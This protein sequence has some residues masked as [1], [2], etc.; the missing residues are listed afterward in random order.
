MQQ[1]DDL[2]A[3]RDAIQLQVTAIS[4]VADTLKS[5]LDAALAEIVSLQANQLS[6]QDLADIV[7]VTTDLQAAA[8][9]LSDKA[10]TDSPAN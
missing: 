3:S 9:T 7:Q 10:A 2:K 8:Q 4:T 6:S 1:V 5:K